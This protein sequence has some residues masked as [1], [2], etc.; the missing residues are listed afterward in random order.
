MA[1][2]IP[3][4]AAHDHRQ[5]PE[6]G[7]LGRQRDVHL[8]LATQYLPTRITTITSKILT[9][10]DSAI[11][12]RRFDAV[13]QG[14]KGRRR[15]SAHD[16]G[17]AALGGAERRRIASPGNGQLLTGV[18]PTRVWPRSAAF[19]PYN[20]SAG[21]GIL[22][23]TCS[24]NPP[25]YIAATSTDLNNA[26]FPLLDDHSQTCQGQP[27]SIATIGP[28][29]WPQPSAA[30]RVL[31]RIFPL[32]PDTSTTWT[33]RSTSGVARTMMSIRTR[34]LTTNCGTLT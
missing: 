34:R 33:T 22:I 5:W 25:T 29:R 15:N 14:R 2:P 20:R 16:D 21:N 13:H 28:P 4:D 3:Q 12:R 27:A 8:Q 23:G 24:N 11:R 31:Y 7:A 9:S 1:E 19:D 17:D 32:L 30:E 26:Y 10:T 6:R 18:S